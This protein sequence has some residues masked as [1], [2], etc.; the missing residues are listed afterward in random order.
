METLK[1]N[2]FLFFFIIILTL[3]NCQ[4][5]K[6]ADKKICSNDE[7]VHFYNSTSMSFYFYGKYKNISLNNLK[8][9]QIKA[10]KKIIF[11]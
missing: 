9:E 1:K 8:I 2:K 7:L 6:I 4:D 3:L 5:K 10:S 11:F